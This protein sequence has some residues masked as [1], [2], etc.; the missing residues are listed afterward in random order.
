MASYKPFIGLEIHVE[1][2]TKSKMF[3]G[4]PA[5]H[6]GRQ[7]NTITCPVCLGLPGALPVPNRQAVEW[8]IMLGLALNCRINE[9][10]KFDRKHYF[11]PDLP[12]GYQIS[13]YDQPFCYDG[14]LELTLKDG[15]HKMIRISRVHI[16]EDTGKL[17]HTKLENENV[18]LADFNRSGVPLVEI[19]S[20]PDFNNSEEVDIFVKEIHQIIRYLDISSA[21]MEKGTMR[22][23]PSISLG[24]RAKYK[25]GQLPDWR[26][27]LKNINSFRF[28]RN[29]LEYEINRQTYILASGKNPVQE[30]RGWNES[31]K[32]TQ[33]QRAKESAQDYRYF[34]EPDIPPMIWSKKQV[35]LISNQLPE[36]PLVK[37]LRLQHSYGL[38]S[39]DAAQLTEA[40]QRA[41][42]F[43]ECVK[44]SNQRKLKQIT[45]K[46]IA[47]WIIN[48]KPDTYNTTPNQLIAIISES[49]RRSDIMQEDLMQAIT[50]ILAGNQKA[51]GDYRLGKTAAIMFLIGMV[52]RKLGGRAD[53]KL[54]KSELTR[55]L[56]KS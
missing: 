12:K 31:K 38:T 25:N 39:Y 37:K 13:Q 33:P 19:V 24:D 26:V 2:A 46:V 1:L 22:I 50:A 52:I 21:D 20:E 29:A 43:E 56:E 28:V 27:E 53:A 17:I 42:Y 48:K 14:K 18:A 3:C 34:P 5:D 7:P 15:C 47:N 40:R 44:N 9:E 45:P 51:V 10:S 36:L 41:E 55:I 6:F 11:Y 8:T 4:C 23:E 16:E 30:T 49:L 54:V 32:V 35:K